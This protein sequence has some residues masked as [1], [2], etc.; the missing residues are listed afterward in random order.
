MVNN[1]INRLLV[2]GACVLSVNANKRTIITNGPVYPLTEAQSLLKRFGLLVINDQADFD[3]SNEFNPEL[4]D[5]ELIKFIVAL[6]ETDYENS[7]RCGTSAGKT[8][9]CDAYAM[10]WNRHRRER[11]DHGFKIYVKFGFFENNPKCLVVSIHPA[12]W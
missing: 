12:R 5:E 9:D 1:R 6:D 3:Q 8:I 4:D 11:W 10:K 2:S 7:E